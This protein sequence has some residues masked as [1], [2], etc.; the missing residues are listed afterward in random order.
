MKAKWML[1][2][3]STQKMNQTDKLI[4]LTLQSG[5]YSRFKTDKNFP[6]EAYEKLYITWIKKSCDK[7]IAFRIL[8]YG[9]MKNPSG[10][11]TLTGNDSEAQIGLI[12]V[13]EQH[14]GQGIGRKLIEAAINTAKNHNFTTLKVVTQGANQQACLLYEKCG[15]VI[16]SKINIY[17]YWNKKD[18]YPI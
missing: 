17:H 10:F 5:I 3:S 6:A 14:R 16:D 12:A 2:F 11:I 7:S 9:E 1:Q 18:A 8:I 15:F 13:D 4:S